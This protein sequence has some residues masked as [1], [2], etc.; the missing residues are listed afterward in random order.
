MRPD[1]TCVVGIALGE[2]GE[3]RLARAA[4]AREDLSQQINPTTDRGLH[5]VAGDSVPLLLP[6][7]GPIPVFGRY[8]R[9]ERS[10]HVS[11]EGGFGPGD[12]LLHEW[13]N[14]EPSLLGPGAQACGDLVDPTAALLQSLQVIAGRLGVRDDA[15][16]R[17]GE[18]PCGAA[19][20]HG[21][22]GVLDCLRVDHGDLLL[23]LD[24]EAAERDPVGLA[25]CRG[26]D[27]IGFSE[28]LL[29]TIPPSGLPC[30]ARVGYS[31][32]VTGDAVIA[33]VERVYLKPV[34]VE[35]VG[36]LSRR[37]HAWQFAGPAWR[38]LG[39]VWAARVAQIT[40]DRPG[41]PPLSGRV[42]SCGANRRSD[43][44]RRR[45]GDGWQGRV[46]GLWLGETASR[47]RTSKPIFC[48]DVRNR[49][50]SIGHG[51]FD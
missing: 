6:L 17:Y 9:R 49:Q 43:G 41:L 14:R 47:P 24:D 20:R 44:G 32:V 7:R 23:G 42:R 21:R 36:E 30:L 5:D 1:G 50:G 48:Q 2:V 35:A 34:R 46:M 13:S 22:D 10:R 28:Q 8:R 15:S 33:G 40:P 45:G 31:V 37:S 39:L 4:G 26:V 11:R 27:G 3:S 12:R 25:H 18:Q 19:E 29:D 16:R 51:R 38:L